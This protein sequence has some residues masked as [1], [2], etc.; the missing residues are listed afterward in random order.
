M[1]LKEM[2]YIMLKNENL[3]NKEHYDGTTG[4]HHSNTGYCPSVHWLDFNTPGKA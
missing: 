2:P 3:W 1:K 4:N